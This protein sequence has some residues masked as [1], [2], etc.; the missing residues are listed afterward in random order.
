MVNIK[1]SDDD[2]E[3]K[4]KKRKDVTPDAKQNKEKVFIPYESINPHPSILNL[5]SS[6]VNTQPLNIAKKCEIAGISEAKSQIDPDSLYKLI[7]ELTTRVTSLETQLEK[8]DEELFNLRR[9]H[10]T[11]H[12]QL[13][14]LRKEKPILTTE[15]STF[16]DVVKAEL[17]KISDNVAEHESEIVKLK[18]EVADIKSARDEEMENEEDAGKLQIKNEVQN[19]INARKADQ[20]IFVSEFRKN[21]L[22]G[23]QRDQ[24][25]M[26]DTIRVTGVP[27]KKDE[28]TNDLIRRIAWSIGVTVNKDDISVSHRTGKRR[29]NA[30]RAII[31]RFTRRDVKHEIIRNKK[32]AKNIKYDDD[33]RPVKIYIDEKLTPMRANICR[34][35]RSQKTDH[36]T[37]DGKIFIPNADR[38]D[39]AESQWKVLDRAEDW[40]N[41]EVSDKIKT[42]LGIFPKL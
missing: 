34:Y 37:W 5:N 4:S 32:Q 31:C 24:Y 36:H 22:D 27:F 11:L 10:A 42:D 18:E 7:C 19:L 1:M 20:K 6:P 25:S 15:D 40:L 28:D 23:D 38:E 39:R 3:R 13:D 8:K 17:P 41:W 35:L 16:L 21:H 26:K 33:G 14:E 9:D 12:Q 2:Q 29:A 30:P